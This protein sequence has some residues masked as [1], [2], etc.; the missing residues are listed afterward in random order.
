MRI[1]FVTSPGI[2]HIFPSVP[3]AWALRSAGHDVLMATSGYH[4]IAARA[5]L[6]VVDT[7]PAVD[8]G[9]VF[10]GFF[11]EHGQPNTTSE[12]HAAK[13]FATVS[14]KFVDHTVE[15]AKYWRPDLVITT[16]MQGAGPLAAA[17]VGVPWVLHGIS[18][19]GSPETSKAIATEMA[20]D[21]Q[22]LG[23]DYEAPTAFL[24]VSPPSLR[25]RESAGWSM[26]YV[27]YNGGA[28]LEPWLVRP[29]E[30]PRITVTLGSVLPLMG[31][32]KSLETFVASAG[33]VDAEFVLALDGAD[34]SELG[35]LPENVRLVD[36]IPLG[37]LL[38]VCD[39]VIHHGGA[40]TTF[41]ALDAGLPQLVLPQMAD[42]PLNAAAVARS[43]AGA[44]VQSGDLDAGRLSGLL[45]DNGMISAAKRIAAEI[46]AQPTPMELVPKIVAL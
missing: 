2:G 30:R 31:G 46:A 18:L 43:G 6:Q 36:W 17:V 33:A 13:L 21:Y 37:S 40:G 23:V 29:R 7:A 24:D 34:V 38:H 14:G 32:V 3:I 12:D 16:L 44:V 35:T 1:L 28:V 25:Q 8:F 4:D 39:A 5:G 41:T 11:A 42:Q 27:P 45:T 22:R 15:L 26:R 10:Q 9:Q 19:A 20:A